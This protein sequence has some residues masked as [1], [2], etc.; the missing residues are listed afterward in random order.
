[1]I[2]DYIKKVVEGQDL[3][4]NEMIDTM[5]I[6][7]VGEATPAQ[8]GSF[9][10]ALRLKGETVDEIKGAATVMRQKATPIQVHSKTIVDTCGTGG[11]E[12]GTFNISTAAAFV[13]A[14]AGLTVAKHGNRS[15]SSLSGSADVLQSLGVNVEA[16]T[17]R[18]EQCLN[19]I[20][21]GFLFAPFF[22]PAMKHVISSRREI[23]IRTIFNVLG[24]LTNPLEA[25]SQVIGVYSKSLTHTL[26]DVLKGFGAKHVFVVHGC[27]GLDEITLTGCS[28]VSE[29][30]E[31]KI[32]NWK[33]EPETY[34][35]PLCKPEDLKGGYP[36]EN[37]EIIQKILNGEKGPKRDITV[38]NAAAVI[39]AGGMAEN[40]EKGIS[41]ASESIDSGKSL[42]KLQLLKK[43]SFQ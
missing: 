31:N 2:K 11:D 5:N 18:V 22:H 1:M 36:N 3:T 41:L 40:F 39:I 15:V 6:I 38:L 30:K 27:D 34:G 26:A 37:A 17:K 25:P 16:E 8:I 23:G 12:S 42:E 19:E 28:H 21:I 33:L 4:E 43:L 10:T 24:P 32:H 35:L 13:A 29:L 14:G 9:L 7:M 20:G